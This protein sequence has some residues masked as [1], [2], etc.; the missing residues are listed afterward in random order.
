L[1]KFENII[2]SLENNKQKINVGDVVK[3]N[4]TIPIIK[5]EFYSLLNLNGIVTGITSTPSIKVYSILFE[6]KEYVSYDEQIFEFMLIKVS[7]RKKVYN[8]KHLLIEKEII[9]PIIFFKNTK[10]KEIFW[11]Y[12]L[13]SFYIH[14]SHLPNN[15]VGECR[16]WNA[17]KYG[18]QINRLTYKEGSYNTNI[19]ERI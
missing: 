1:I 10:S 11:K 2:Y 4:E 15:Y 12:F 8:S 3:L 14:Y 16:R 5:R 18:E 7:S 19:Y 13:M 9:S 6:N 17:I